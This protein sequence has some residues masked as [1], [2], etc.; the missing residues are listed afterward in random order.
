MQI[1]N[2]QLENGNQT[3]L[4]IFKNVAKEM[5]AK[6]KIDEPKN[7]DKFYNIKETQKFK[8][9]KKWEKENTQE[10]KQIQQ[11]I[12]EELKGYENAN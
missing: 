1:I 2:M 7:K 5:G 12:E 3:I 10:A 9:F 11:E 6:L 8:N 4:N